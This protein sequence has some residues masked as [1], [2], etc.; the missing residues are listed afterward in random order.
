LRAQEEKF[1]YRINEEI[2]A[3]EVRV[4]GDG[5]EPLILPI[6]KAIALAYEKI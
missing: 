5:F 4:V 2:T 3:R 6:D 1:S